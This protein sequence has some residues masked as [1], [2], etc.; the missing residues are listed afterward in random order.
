M[1]DVGQCNCWVW[2]AMR[3]GR[4]W[5]MRD[6]GLAEAKRLWLGGRPLEAGRALAAL[7]PERER[8]RWAGRVLAWAYRRSGIGS[9]PAVDGVIAAALGMSGVDGEAAFAAIEEA[10]GR[11]EGDGRFDSLREAVLTLARNAARLVPGAVAE[12]SDP[13]VA[14]WFVASLK[15]V[16]DE[17][18]E[19][20]AAEAWP[21]LAG[22]GD[23]LGTDPSLH[24][25]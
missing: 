22:F 14:W 9:E 19:G 21:V 6:V 13:R 8:M 4:E 17:L 16:G 11:A 12:P 3:V 2:L 20:F 10:L 1:S 5:R 24:S 25:G 15:C 7:V 23:R 18:E